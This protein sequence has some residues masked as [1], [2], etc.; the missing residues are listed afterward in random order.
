MSNVQDVSKKKNIVPFRNCILKDFF[1]FFFFSLWT[2]IISVSVK[3]L[4]KH[5][6]NNFFL[7][8]MISLNLLV[9]VSL[10]LYLE[11]P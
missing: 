10:K 8:L 11:V 2:H 3:G 9:I 5:K 4:Q 1:F 6:K 7:L